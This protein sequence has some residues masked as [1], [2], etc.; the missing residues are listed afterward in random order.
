MYTAERRCSNPMLVPKEKRVDISLLGEDTDLR[1]RLS[2][3]ALEAERLLVESA[4]SVQP[5]LEIN[6]ETGASIVVRESTDEHGISYICIQSASSR[7]V[8][9]GPAPALKIP[10]KKYQ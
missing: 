3:A 10:H 1:E 5:A 4:T 9:R 7:S 6:N 2:A 8:S